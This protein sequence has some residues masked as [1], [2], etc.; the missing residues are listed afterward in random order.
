MNDVGGQFAAVE[1]ER[2]LIAAAQR[3]AAALSRSGTH[4]SPPLDTVGGYTLIREIGRGGMGIVYEAEQAH[5]RRAVA[6]KMIKGEARGEVQ[7]QAH[8]RHPGIAAIYEAGR[9]DGGHHFFTMELV[10]GV[11]LAEYARLRQLSL[12]DQ[13]RIFCR[14]CEA[15]HYAHQRGVIHADLKTSNILVDVDGNPKVLDFGLARVRDTDGTLSDKSLRGSQGG[16]TLPY[17]SPEQVRT[18]P[19]EALDVRC[20]VYALGMILYELMTGQL[21][22]DISAALPRAE[23]ERIICEQPPAPPGKTNVAV[24]GDLETIILKALAKEPAQRY[25]GA[26]ALADD[27]TRYLANW[28][29]RARPPSVPYVLCKWLSRHPLRVALLLI[30]GAVLSAFAVL[31]QAQAVQMAAVQQEIEEYRQAGS[32]AQRNI[33]VANL[34][35]I[36]DGLQSLGERLLSEHDYIAADAVLA[37]CAGIRVQYLG[38]SHP[39]TAYVESLHGECLA[40]L[41][42]FEE[43]EELLDKGYAGIRDSH[44]LGDADTQAAAQRLIDLYQEWGKPAE[45]ARWRAELESLRS[46]SGERPATTSP[47]E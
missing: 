38:P 21:P 44:T 30:T 46:M 17:M 13:L 6:L 12:R 26:A 9:T 43:A 33:L 31:F 35:P 1:H 10:R 4:A 8:L 28:P 24:R 25:D 2:G 27:I 40:K 3:E 32:P 14:L 41:G 5:P 20:D 34:R 16:G 23:V 7:I 45:A 37:I 47:S 19:D 18:R 29:I 15:V 36:M 42:R 39:L 22:Y 11:P